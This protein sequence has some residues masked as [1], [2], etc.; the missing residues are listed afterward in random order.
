[1]T[2]PVRVTAWVHGRVQGVGFRYWTQD[3]AEALG[4]AGSATNQ[5]DGTVEVIAEGPRPACEQLIEALRG[6]M[7]PGRVQRVVERWGSAHGV[8]DRFVTR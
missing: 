4:L 2:D 8:G 1:M 5:L 6:P 3:R 7:T